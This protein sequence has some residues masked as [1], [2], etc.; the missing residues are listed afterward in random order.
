MAT[1]IKQLIALRKQHPSLG[2]GVKGHQLR[3]WVNPEKTD[4]NNLSK[5]PKRGGHVAHPRI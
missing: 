1:W 2:T 5:K 4:L 3:V